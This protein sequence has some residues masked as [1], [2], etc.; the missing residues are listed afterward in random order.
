MRDLVDS[1]ATHMALSDL[2]IT[3][4]VD[5]ETD[6]IILS[7]ASVVPPALKQ[8]V[9][10]FRSDIV[11]DWY[12]QRIFLWIKEELGDREIP[13]TPEIMHHEIQMAE[14]YLGSIDVFKQAVREYGMA[15][16]RTGK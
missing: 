15:V 10:Q 5:P 16:I 1:Y 8:A 6:E 11:R 3:I 4:M 14:L 9:R 7:P 2:E 13:L 12:I